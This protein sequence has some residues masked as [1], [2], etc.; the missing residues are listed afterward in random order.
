[1]QNNDKSSRKKFNTGD[2]I[3]L[4]VPTWQDAQDIR[5]GARKFW[6]RRNMAP[7]NEVNRNFK[8]KKKKRG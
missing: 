6:E 8:G 1:M 5:E 2:A 4:M 3:H 7:P